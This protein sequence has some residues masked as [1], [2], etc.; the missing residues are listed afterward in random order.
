MFHNAGTLGAHYFFKRDDPYLRSP[1]HMLNTVVHHLALQYEPY[2]QAVASAI[3]EYSGLLD[4]PLGQRYTH[5]VERP[6]RDLEFSFASPRETLVIVVDAIDECENTDSRRTLLAYLRE[7]SW[8]APWFKVVVTS[9]PDEDIKSAFDSASYDYVYS[10]SLDDYDSSEDMMEYTQKRM[11]RIAHRKKLQWDDDMI[12]KLSERAGGLFIW[13]E[14]A[15]KFIER[16]ANAKGRLNQ[17]LDGNQ[18]TEGYDQLD[19]L[20]MIAIQQAMGDQGTD[21]MRSYRECIG[22]IVVTGSRKPL[23]VTDLA[24]LLSSYLEP[25]VLH[26]VVRGLGS[27]LYEDPNQT[28]AIRV[29]HPSFAD[30]ILDPARSKNFHTDPKQQEAML[31][32]C[33]LKTMMRELSFNVCGLETSHLLN[34]EVPNFRQRV[35]TAINQRLE[36]SCMHWYSHLMGASDCDLQDQLSG[37]LYGSQLLFWIEVMS[38]LGQLSVA[39]SSLLGLIDWTSVSGKRK[40]NKSLY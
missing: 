14:T 17:I 2:G 15:C 25:E 3:E 5:L 39:L 8:I 12:R 23:S 27:V 31:A 37:F 18:P 22:A 9:R 21:N 28:G 10:L 32:N 29:Y 35:L 40:L 33:C 30:F 1:E 16:G 6:L 11:A 4:M 13:M 36:Y 34:D 19:S 7:M 26:A 20:Y 24:S 38:L